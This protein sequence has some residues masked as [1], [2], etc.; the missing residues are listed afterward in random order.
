MWLNEFFYI[1]KSDRKVVLLLFVIIV[2]SFLIIHFTD[3]EGS[4]KPY[5]KPYKSYKSNKSYKRQGATPQ[6]YRQP[7]RQVE[8]FPFDPNTADSTQLLRLGLEPWQVRN[9]YKY[10]AAGG[11]YR[12][13]EDFARLYGL[14]VGQYRELE[15]FMQISPDFLPASTLL[16]N[17]RKEREREQETRWDSLPRY[18]VK[19]AEGEQVDINAADTLVYRTVPGIGSYYSR[20]I[21]DYGH[22]L[23]GYVCVD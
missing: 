19:I 9:I 20:K 4:D 8:R 16:K 12:E 3:G 21:L 22:R 17:R 1:R 11:I 10:R 7:E 5:G 6:Y 14:T 2:L 13:K 18:P 23:G 15:P